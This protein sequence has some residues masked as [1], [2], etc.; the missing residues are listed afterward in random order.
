MQ[1]TKYGW[2]TLFTDVNIDPYKLSMLYQALSS[3]LLLFGYDELTLDLFMASNLVSVMKYT[4]D[5]NV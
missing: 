4:K 2:S 3:D 1:D 5:K